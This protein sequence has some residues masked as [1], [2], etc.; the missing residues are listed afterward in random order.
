[1]RLVDAPAD[2]QELQLDVR[3][4]EIDKDGEGW[5]VL[6]TPNLVVDLLTLTGG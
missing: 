3:R 2:Y 5:I 1:M 6:G 4:V